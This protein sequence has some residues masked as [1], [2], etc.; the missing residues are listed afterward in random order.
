MVFAIDGTTSHWFEVAPVKIVVIKGKYLFGLV[1]GF[2]ERN[3]GP[4]IASVAVGG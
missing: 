2:L 1:D 4:F 3:L